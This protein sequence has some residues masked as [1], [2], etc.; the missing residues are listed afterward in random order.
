MNI[1]VLCGGTST[2]REI[3]I[4]S[5]TMVCKALID[6]GHNARLLDVF[7]G[8]KN[9]DFF[10]GD[11][12]VEAGSKEISSFNDEVNELKNTRKVFMGENILEICSK[13]DVVF[14]ALHGSNGEDGKIQATFDL[15]GIKYTGTDYLGSALAMDKNISK[16]IFMYNNVPTPVGA[17]L[18]KGKTFEEYKA[19][20]DEKKISCPCVVKPACGG[21]SVGVYIPENEEE[22][23]K[24]IED[25]FEFE[26]IIVVEEYVKGREFSIGVIDGKALP[27]IEIIPLEGFYDYT[28]KY[29]PGKTKDVCPA[30]ISKE[31]TEKMQREAEHAAKVLRLGVYSRIDFLTDENDNIYCLEANTLPGMTPTSLLPQE[32]MALGI[33]FGSLCEMLIEKSMR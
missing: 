16:Q 18:K 30:E 31:L 27:I 19:M 4:V 24:A 5:G 7:I 12:D 15:F 25:A 8:S 11:Y 3:S 33:D 23:N 14:M 2:E 26:D 9:I 17:E 20:L 22:L 29:E 32:A 1:V 28:N 21:S 13:A 6:K 10:A